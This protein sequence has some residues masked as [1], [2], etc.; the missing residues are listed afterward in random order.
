MA[1]LNQWTSL[2]RI[3]IAVLP[4]ACGLNAMRQLSSSVPS[5]YWVITDPVQTSASVCHS[6]AACSAPGSFSAVE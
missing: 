3:P 6:P 5:T 4:A 1:P 2:I